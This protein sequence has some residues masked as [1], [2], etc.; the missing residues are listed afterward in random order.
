MC[1]F[2]GITITF[3]N[4]GFV[5]QKY[6]PGGGK[7][8][9]LWRIEMKKKG[10]VLGTFSAKGG[11]GKTT[12]VANLGASI[13]QKLRNRVIVVETNMT[14]SNLGLHLGILDPPVVIQD[15]IFGKNKIEEA[16]LTTEYGL[17]IVAGTV[18]FTEELGSI[19]LMPIL[20][21]LR[22]RYDLIILD[23]APGFALEVIASM[24]C[25]DE[26][27]VVCQLQVPAIAGT[28]QSFRF[29]EKYKVPVL[30]VVMTQVMGKR[31][32]IPLSEVR[33]TLKWPILAVIPEDDMV[34][35]SI[36]R[37]I[38]VVLYAPESS[39]AV[40]YRKLAQLVLNHLKIRKKRGKA[41]TRG[42]K[43]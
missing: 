24:R 40:E 6:G 7:R 9:E 5:T 36:T 34:K 16:I 21:L 20:D 4:M 10:V 1:I 11:V 12:T 37:G 29:A 19:N 35:E 26:L 28:L 15:V 27:L 43:R 17:H 13:A 42:R 8:G 31:F 2:L 41:R 30:G 22:K 39:A 33:K 14:A 38:P 32:E 3:L 25:V 18:A 23:S